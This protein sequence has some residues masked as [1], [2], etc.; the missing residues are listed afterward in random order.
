[1]TTN[2]T[3]PL[4]PPRWYLIA[5]FFAAVI[6][7][8]LYTQWEINHG[9]SLHSFV[10]TAQPIYKD[11]I[12]DWLSGL[13]PYR[14]IHRAL[15]FVY[16]PVFLYAGG[17]LARIFPGL[18][19]WYLYILVIVVSTLALPVVLARFY[20]CQPW[21]TPAFA[22]LI[23]LAEPRLTGVLALANGNIAAVLY[24]VTFLAAVPG[25]RANRWTLFYVAVFAGALV[26]FPF[27]LLLLLPLLTGVRQWRNS[28]VCVGAV[29]LAYLLQK[30]AVPDL[31]SGYKWSVDQQLTVMNHYGYGVLGIVAGLQNKLYG[32]VGVLPSV[33][34][35]LFTGIQIAVLFVLRPRIQEPTRNPLWLALVVLST[36]FASPRLLEY[37]ADVALFAAYVI[38]AL[39]LQTRRLLTLLIILFLPSLIVSHLIKAQTLVGCYETLV[40]L[41]AF[42]G[43][44][45][46]LWRRHAKVSL[47]DHEPALKHA[48]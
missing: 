11:A 46:V 43:A 40:L 32:K 48:V 7:R 8:Y 4:G 39:V 16:P 2:S 26:K 30:F 28:G 35:V 24:L 22:I 18:I 15:R 37:D 36:I 27:L 33:L 21:L 1:M 29:V 45:A 19:G 25:L 31:Y 23:F 34:S 14:T 6:C 10:L 12:S 17:W 44:F 38:F 42:A 9:L 3:E 47:A 41:L 13:D 20:F 5:L